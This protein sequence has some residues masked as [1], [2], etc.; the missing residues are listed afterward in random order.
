[1]RR[2][3]YRES[4][5]S[6]GNREH[7]VPSDPTFTGHSTPREVSRFLFCVRLPGR[8]VYPKFEVTGGE[9]GSFTDLLYYPS[10]RQKFQR[11]IW[12]SSRNNKPWLCES[13]QLPIKENINGTFRFYKN[14]TVSV[15]VDKFLL[16]V[17]AAKGGPLIHGTH[18]EIHKTPELCPKST[19]TSKWCQVSPSCPPRTERV[20]RTPC[21]RE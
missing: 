1:M 15:S 9:R 4:N 13:V 20:P 21:T 12:R 2:F 17:Q 14:I 5:N 10:K 6:E 19:P 16:E 7:G 18:T 3:T 8:K 11:P